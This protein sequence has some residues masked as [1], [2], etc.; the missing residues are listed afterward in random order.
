MSLLDAIANALPAPGEPVLVR[1]PAADAAPR[2]LAR[3]VL[4]LGL[5]PVTLDADR[6]A[7]ARSSAN[8]SGD[9]RPLFEFRQLVDPLPGLS[10]YFAA[11]GSST[12]QLYGDI[13]RGAAVDRDESFAAT[14]IAGSRKSFSDNT[15]PNMDGNPGVWRPVYTDL[16]DWAELTDPGRFQPLQIDLTKAGGPDGPYATIGGVDALGLSCGGGPGGPPLDPG[17]SLHQLEMTYLLVSLVRPWFNRTLFD[18]AGWHLA[19]QPSGWCSSGTLDD[20]AGVIPLVPTALLLAKDVKLAASWGPENRAFVER[21]GGSGGPLSLGPFLLDQGRGSSALQVVGWLSALT[22]FAPRDSN[23]RA[24]SVL[25][26]N[27]GAFT[28]R[29]SVSWRERGQTFTRQ[30]KA[31]LALAAE[32]IEVP[33]D[34]RDILVTIDVMTFPAPETWKTVTS[35]RFDEPPDRRFALSGTT[36]NPGIVESVSPG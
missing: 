26:D 29:F 21:A 36:F 35:A 8:P 3:P 11:S 34:A 4:Q 9:L 18:V 23:V 19:G 30:S 2:A 32:A 7:H 22:P 27:R 24:G 12:E 17:T 1:G 33:A 14:V 13:L 5:L 28:A 16:G 31:L 10:R 20:N 6:L 25:V 15:F